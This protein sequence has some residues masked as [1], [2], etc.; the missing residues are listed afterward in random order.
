M[1]VAFIGLGVMGWPMAAHVARDHDVTVSN[2]TIAK[3]RSWAEQHGARVAETP[4][5]AAAEADVVMVCVPTDADTLEVALGADGAFDAIRPGA[6]FLDHGSGTPEVAR[7]LA[8]E[9][10]LRG[11]GFLDAPVTG[12]AIGAEAARLAVMVGGEAEVLEPARPAIDCFAARVELMGPVG[13]GHLTKMVNVIIG[14]GS[15]LALAEAL[16]FAIRS[17]LD[18]ARVVGVLME[19]S[20]RSWQLEH[21]AGAMIGRDY[22]SR[23]PVTFARKDLGNVLAEARKSALQLPVSALA[24]QIYAE[25]QERGWGAADTASIM[26]YFVPSGSGTGPSA[27]AG[28]D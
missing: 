14:H 23:Y 27:P 20:S 21:R 8:A 12:G 10:D 24:D 7:R 17:G 6:V 25:L 1:K 22:R 11:I 15:G 2:R 16:G 19:G 13:A 28:Q 3:A 26:E 9:A 4:A 5:A 18:P